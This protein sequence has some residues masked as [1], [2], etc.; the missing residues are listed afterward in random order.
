M[1][2]RDRRSMILEVLK[3]EGK[4]INGSSLAKRFEVSR[5]VIVQD[6][7]LLR[8][9]GENI[10]ATPQGYLIPIIANDKK[11]IK[12]IV[13][14]HQGY[15][16]MGEELQIMI[17]FGARVL[18]VIVEHPV[19]GEIKGLLDISNKQDLDEFLKKISNQKAEPLSTLT[20]GVHIHTLEIESE[21]NFEKMRKALKEK[22]YLISE[23]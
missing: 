21:M 11:L 16:K 7:A 13:S 20:E 1:S 22:G 3:E 14:K 2:S 18:D 19:Y 12:T 8:A 5:Q 6:I 9:Q 23:D 15:E 17:D 10:I 4:P